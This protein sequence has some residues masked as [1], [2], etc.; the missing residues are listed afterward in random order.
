MNKFRPQ[1]F[2]KGW[3]IKHF[4]LTGESVG[5]FNWQSRVQW[6]RDSDRNRKHSIRVFGQ[7]HYL[8]SHA[9]APVRKRWHKIEMNFI[10][11]RVPARGSIRYLNN[12]SSG[13]WL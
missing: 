13:R 7:L 4:R 1:E 9:P 5:I 8:G 12:I 10:N 6:Y 11:K 3:A 2:N